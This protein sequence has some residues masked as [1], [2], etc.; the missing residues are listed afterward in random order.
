[1]A[2][3]NAAPRS[4]T[5]PFPAPPPFWKHFTEENVS[6]L[7]AIIKSHTSD[8]SIT[9]NAQARSL[10]PAELRALEVP[11]DL[12]YLIPPPPPT[13]DSYEV[14]SDTINVQS[15]AHLPLL[16]QKVTFH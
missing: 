2:E 6:R 5:A 11:Q 13:G 3:Q 10:K 15:N 1:M 9:P 16:H 12:S 7:E 14:F 4:I 8:T